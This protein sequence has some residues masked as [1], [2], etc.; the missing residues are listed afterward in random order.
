M[1]IKYKSQSGK[2]KTVQLTAPENYE[3]G[4]STYFDEVLEKYDIND[5][6]AKTK[7]A[8]ERQVKQKQW[9]EQRKAAEQKGRLQNELFKLK[10]DFLNKKIMDEST[11][12]QRKA[13]RKAD[14]HEKLILI[15]YEIV[16]QYAENNNKSFFEAIQEIDLPSE[17]NEQ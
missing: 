17:N 6:V 5:L 3:K 16:R 12:E 14:T 4:K 9:E 8:V 1:E 10:V 7:T 13:I 2:T 15:K 11:A